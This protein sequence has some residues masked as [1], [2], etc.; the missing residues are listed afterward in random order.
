DFGPYH[1]ITRS[2]KAL[3]HA[4]QG[5]APDRRILIKIHTKSGDTV[6]A[7]YKNRRAGDKSGRSKSSFL[8]SMKAKAEVTSMSALY[9][10]NAAFSSAFYGVL[11]EDYDFYSDDSPSGV[12]EPDDIADFDLYAY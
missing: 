5:L 2:A 11:S 10:N 8:A 6:T 4:V 1:K 9:K 3:T 7:V 12:P